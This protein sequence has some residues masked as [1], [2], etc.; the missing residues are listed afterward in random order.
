MTALWD[1]LTSPGQPPAVGLTTLLVVCVA[2]LASTWQLRQLAAR[3]AELH[4]RLDLLSAH[5]AAAAGS[6]RR[7]ER[8]AEVAVATAALSNAD[9]TPARIQ[10][11]A[12]VIVL[13]VNSLSP[14][15]LETSV[16]PSGRGGVDG[17]GGP[18]HTADFNRGG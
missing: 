12:A 14:L 11:D 6:A 7:G 8:A 9:G 10:A 3:L 15:R 16:G 5:A 13:P 4:E 17:A 18:G 1:T 2:T